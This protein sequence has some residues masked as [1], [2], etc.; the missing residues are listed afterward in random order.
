MVSGRSAA[1][2]LNMDHWI[3]ESF[4]AAKQTEY[5]SSPIGAGTGPFT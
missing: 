3:N 4:D 1:D 5:K 2:D